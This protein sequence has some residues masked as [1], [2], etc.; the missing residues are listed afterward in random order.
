MRRELPAD[1]FEE[2]CIYAPGIVKFT[3]KP[4]VRKAA[5]KSINKRQRRKGREHLRKGKHET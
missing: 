5:K 3:D 1:G 2:D 4:G